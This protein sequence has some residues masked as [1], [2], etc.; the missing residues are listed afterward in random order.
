[1]KNR[2]YILDQ[3][4]RETTWWSNFTNHFREK[5]NSYAEYCDYRDDQLSKF[6]AIF[7]NGHIIFKSEEDMVLFLLK[8][9]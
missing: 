9:S 4:L 6:H 8:F 1:M 5:R 7:E 2:L 3:N